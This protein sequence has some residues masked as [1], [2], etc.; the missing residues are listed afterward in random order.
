MEVVEK[1]LIFIPRM[2]QGEQKQGHRKKQEELKLCDHA[3]LSF[4]K[5]LKLLESSGK[6]WKMLDR[7]RHV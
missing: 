7:K 3:S 6:L 1:E 5:I 4:Q 2:I